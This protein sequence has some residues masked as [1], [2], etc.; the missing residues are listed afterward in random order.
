M[1]HIHR[2]QNN[3]IDRIERT[4]WP[5][6]NRNGFLF[7]LHNLANSMHNQRSISGYLSSFLIYQ[8]LCEEIIK[9]LIECSNLFIQCTIFPNEF[10]PKKLD[11]KTFGQLIIELE[12][13]VCNDETHLLIKKCKELNALRIRMVHKVT[14]KTSVKDIEKQAKSAKKMYDQ[15]YKFFSE[16]REVYNISFGKYNA[17]E[18]R[19]LI[20]NF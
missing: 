12:N 13:G 9:L 18:M 16:I 14:L 17:D 15:A 1:K 3:L 19:E 5:E 8:Q 2:Y 20:R 11:G 4:D 6:F 10:K 7:E